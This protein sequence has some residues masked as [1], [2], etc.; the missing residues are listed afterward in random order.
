MAQTKEAFLREKLANFAAFARDRGFPE[1]LGRALDNTKDYSIG[2]VVDFI[3]LKIVPHREAIVA[4]DN[5]VLE[6]ALKGFGVKVDFRDYPASDV[7]KVHQYLECFCDC[8]KDE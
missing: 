7:G 8:V 1:Q 3:S 6:K 5:S 4:G 2:V